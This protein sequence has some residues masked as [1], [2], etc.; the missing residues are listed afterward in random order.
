[1][2]SH[3]F[4][5]VV[6]PAYFSTLARLHWND[7]GGTWIIRIF[8]LNVDLYVCGSDIN[9]QLIFKKAQWLSK[10]RKLSRFH[11]AGGSIRVESFIAIPR[12]QYNSPELKLSTPKI[13]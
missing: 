8:F 12:E 3:L 9:R 1:M 10:Q 7:E 13:V 2:D 11:V 5:L 6:D 4:S